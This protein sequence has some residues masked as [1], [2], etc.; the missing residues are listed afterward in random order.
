MKSLILFIAPTFLVLALTSCSK[1]AQ[2]TTNSITN[3]T[4]A[5]RPEDTNYLSHTAP[6]I[7]G[8]GVVKFSEGV[9]Q[10]FGLAGDKSC[11]ITAKHLSG[12]T[13][14]IELAFVVEATNADKTVETLA[15]P[16]FRL[17]AGRRCNFTVRGVEIAVTPEWKTP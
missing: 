11:T 12:S 7:G 8:L 13:N 2:T 16:A 14:F 4:A 5:I 1:H 10:Y 3:G 15:T 9:P 17:Q 6:K